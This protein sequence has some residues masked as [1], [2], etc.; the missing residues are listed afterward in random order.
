M[1]ISVPKFER[2][3][4]LV[5]TNRRLRDG[6]DCV[7]MSPRTTLWEPATPFLF[8]E[9]GDVYDGKGDTKRKSP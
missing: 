5:V 9:F 6:L 7:L 1:T 2:S 8:G 3:A 4:W